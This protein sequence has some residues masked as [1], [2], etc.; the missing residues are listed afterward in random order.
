MNAARYILPISDGPFHGAVS[1][2]FNRRVRAFDCLRSS[3]G[4]HFESMSARRGSA[5]ATIIIVAS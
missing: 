2:H 3:G 5:A 4:G 1:V